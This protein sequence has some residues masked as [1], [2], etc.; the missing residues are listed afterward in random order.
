MVTL[1]NGHVYEGKFIGIESRLVNDSDYDELELDT[2][3][4]GIYRSFSEDEIE[5]VKVI[6]AEKNMHEKELS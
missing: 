5:S 4:K 2:G 3:E 1:E 6:L